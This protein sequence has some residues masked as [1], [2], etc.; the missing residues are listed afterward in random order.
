MLFFLIF[1]FFLFFDF[2]FLF[3]F[4][5]L[6][7]KCDPSTF[8]SSQSNLVIYIWLDLLERLSLFRATGISFFGLRLINTWPRFRTIPKLVIKIHAAQESL[9]KLSLYENSHTKKKCNIKVARTERQKD[10]IYKERLV[11]KLWRIKTNFLASGTHFE[12]RE[13]FLW[14]CKYFKNE[15]Y[16]LQKLR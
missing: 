12:L 8:D 3:S 2:L 10:C 5:I 16:S 11:I 6:N 4:P 14:C 9:M 15:L 1:F 7:S 13:L